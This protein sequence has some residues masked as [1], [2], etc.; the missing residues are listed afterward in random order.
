MPHLTVTVSSKAWLAGSLLIE[1]LVPCADGQSVNRGNFIERALLD[2]LTVTLLAGTVLQ[3]Q[4]AYVTVPPGLVLELCC[5]S[6]PVTHRAPGLCDLVGDGVGLGVLLR[7]RD[8]DGLGECDLDGLV[9]VLG[10]LRSSSGWATPRDCVTG[11][12]SDSGSSRGSGSSTGSW[13]DSST[14]SRCCSD[15]GSWWGWRS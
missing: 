5:T 13:R 3:T 6:W 14:G 8:G 9:L 11:C 4:I 15:S 7:V 12:G 10:R 1:H 2:A